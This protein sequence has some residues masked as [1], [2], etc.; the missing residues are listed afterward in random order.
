M[1]WGSGP[2]PRCLG[3]K[4]VAAA[5]ELSDQDLGVA[6]WALAMCRVPEEDGAPMVKALWR[7]TK[8]A[9]QRDEE[10]GLS[11]R[12]AGH[13][14]FAERRV[15]R[16]MRLHSAQ[17]AGALAAVLQRNA[18]AYG[19]AERGAVAAAA[20]YLQAARATQVLLVDDEHDAAT[21]GDSGSAWW[22]ALTDADVRGICRWRRFASG[23]EE[24]AAWPPRGPPGFDSCVLHM[25]FTAGGARYTLAA[26]ASSLRR[27][28]QVLLWGNGSVPRLAQAQQIALKEL[29]FEAVEVLLDSSTVV[30]VFS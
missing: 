30:V 4:V 1:S 23:S 27:G 22:S 5:A 28:A 8:H 19:L 12:T 14:L 13:L 29:G 17:C 18:A 10:S 6:A 24:A 3:E 26:V 21:V 25:P 16:R 7:A 20:A 15:C 11:W 9:E 2:L